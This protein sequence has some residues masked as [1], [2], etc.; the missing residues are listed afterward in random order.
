[1]KNAM[2][3]FVG[4]VAGIAA[5]N[6]PHEK[7]RLT[8]TFKE[9]DPVGDFAEMK[10]RVP[11]SFDDKDDAGKGKPYDVSERTYSVEVP[12]SYDK[13]KPAPL[14]VWI[15]ATDGGGMQGQLRESLAKRGFIYAGAN[16]TGNE[17]WPP[18]RFRAAIDAVFNLKKLYNIDPKQIFIAGN[19]GGGRCASMVS[20]TYPDVFTGGGFY[21]IGCNFWDNLPSE[22][23][24][25]AASVRPVSYAAAGKVRDWT[26]A[27]RAA[28]RIP[29]TNQP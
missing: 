10:R 13:G 6:E 11:S 20:I 28:A 15:S 21:V 23:A 4:L 1:M 14:F 9:S 18:I 27:K 19:S 22:K 12:E 17:I 29:A 25:S 26:K 5:A 2:L 24:G 16:G 7:G 8:L 3:F